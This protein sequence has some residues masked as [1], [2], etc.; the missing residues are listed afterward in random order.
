MASCIIHITGIRGMDV[1][2]VFMVQLIVIFIHLPFNP[3]Y[4]AMWYQLTGHATEEG[5]LCGSASDQPRGSRRTPYGPH[6]KVV[7]TNS[8]T[9]HLNGDLMHCRTKRQYIYKA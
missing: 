3:Q 4:V 6:R 9:S 2:G 7:G 8:W 1:T 5:V